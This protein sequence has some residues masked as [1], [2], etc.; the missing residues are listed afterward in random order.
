ML[1]TTW[2][3]LETGLRDGL[4][5]RKMAKTSG[6]QQLPVPVATAPAFD[7]TGERRLE[8]EPWRGVRHRHCESCRE[9]LPPSA[10]RHRASRRLYSAATQRPITSSRGCRG[11]HRRALASCRPE[12]GRWL[13]ALPELHRRIRAF[14]RIELRPP[15]ML[16]TDWDRAIPDADD[17]WHQSPFRLQSASVERPGIS[18]TNHKWFMEISKLGPLLPTPASGAAR[19][20]LPAH[21]SAR[22]SP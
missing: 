6:Q 15:A 19:C 11:A 12:P 20:Q 16:S 10:Y 4:R 17:A 8:T 9:Q 2:Q 3:K 7:P 1:R 5:H 18:W 14:R 21:A 13:P 22:D